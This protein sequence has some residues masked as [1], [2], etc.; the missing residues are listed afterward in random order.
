MIRFSQ[1]KDPNTFPWDLMGLTLPCLGSVC[2]YLCTATAKYA[3][4]HAEQLFL[5]AR[6]TLREL[7]K[8]SEAYDCDLSG[9]IVTYCEM[10][11]RSWKRESKPHEVLNFLMNCRPFW[12]DFENIL[13][14]M[15]R[16]GR[17]VVKER[18]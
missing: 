9:N 14:K 18:W 12:D 17:V 6:P 11:E 16:D 1:F 7:K 10:I 15:V 8:F 3:P 2:S 5:S 4:T 13:Q